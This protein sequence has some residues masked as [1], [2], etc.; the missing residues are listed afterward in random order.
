MTEK[1][2]VPPGDNEVALDRQ[3]LDLQRLTPKIGFENRVLSR[4][5]RPAPMFVLVWKDRMR[6]FWTPG[7]RWAAAAIA[8]FGSFW[9]TV[10]LANEL[11]PDA[12]PVFAAASQ[13]LG[14]ISANQAR[15]A[16]SAWLPAAAG[17]L[18]GIPAASLSGWSN[19]IAVLAVAPAISLVGLY[20]T[21]KRPRSERVRAYAAR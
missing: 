11:G 10:F 1:N 21:L 17:Y 19:L 8:S 2:Q 14:T 20:F 18:N 9:L 6:T 16:I 7:K 5:W 13:Q 12:Q 3:L 15:E 4:V